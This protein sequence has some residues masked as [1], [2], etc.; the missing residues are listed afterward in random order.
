MLTDDKRCLGER[1]R[2]VISRHCQP[3]G[4]YLSG[5]SSLPQGVWRVDHTAAVITKKEMYVLS[6]LIANH[7]EGQNNACL[8]RKVGNLAG[9]LQLCHAVQGIQDR[10]AL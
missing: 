6:D 2:V 5:A 10:W 1:E 7:Y 4:G 8:C 9:T 3:T